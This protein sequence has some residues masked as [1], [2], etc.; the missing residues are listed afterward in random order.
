MQL[1]GNIL[2][3]TSYFSEEKVETWEKDKREKIGS[4]IEFINQN[5]KE[6]YS[7]VYSNDKS[8]KVDIDIREVGARISIECYIYFNSQIDIVDNLVEVILET[9]DY[10][11]EDVSSIGFTYLNYNFKQLIV[12]ENNR[13]KILN[14]N[15]PEGIKYRIEYLFY[16]DKEDLKNL[17]ILLPNE[18]KNQIMLD[19]KKRID[20]KIKEDSI[21]QSDL[22]RLEKEENERS[23]WNEMHSLGISEEDI[24]D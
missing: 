8:N 13:F 2:Y 14:P 12:F 3:F 6:I 23:F 22:E 7:E 24:Y 17:K 16:R 18:N 9:M 10:L 15:R 21:S 19:L 11:V 1:K 5:S 4:L 20:Y